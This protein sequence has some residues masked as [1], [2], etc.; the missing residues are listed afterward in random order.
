MH[1]PVL[2]QHSVQWF[3]HHLKGCKVLYIGHFRHEVTECASYHKKNNIKSIY[4]RK[5]KGCH[6]AIGWF[7]VSDPITLFSN[8]RGSGQKDFF[9]SF[10]AILQSKTFNILSNGTVIALYF[11]LQVKVN[12][13][14]KEDSFVLEIHK[15]SPKTMTGNFKERP[16]YPKI[17]LYKII[18]NY[19]FSSS[20]YN[21]YR[22]FV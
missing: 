19:L 21:T 12:E 8:D 11:I 14:P 10:S 18:G 15:M 17:A 4:K 2:W 20:S 6:D 1:T 22:Y 3:L 9:S 16:K 13:R 7:W 5:N